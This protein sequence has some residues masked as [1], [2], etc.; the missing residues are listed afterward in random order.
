MSSLNGMVGFFCERNY[1]CRLERNCRCVNVAAIVGAL[2]DANFLAGGTLLSPG[3]KRLVPSLNRG[4]EPNSLSCARLAT[5]IQKRLFTPGTPANTSSIGTR[6][7]QCFCWQLSKHAG[8]A[9]VSQV[10]WERDEGAAHGEC[11]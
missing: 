8:V 3:S 10:D 11:C 5:R 2:F 7:Q 1:R 6:C 9:N 4:T